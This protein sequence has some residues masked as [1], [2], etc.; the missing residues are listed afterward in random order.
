MMP[1]A[2]L[3]DEHLRGKPIWHAIRHHNVGGGLLID[4]TRVG[5][6]ADLPL[7]SSDANILAWSERAGRIIL[8]ED[9]KT[10][11]AGLVLHLRAGR[12]SPGVFLI[13]PGATVASVLSW[14]E[15]VVAVNRPDTR[16]GLVTYLP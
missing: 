4:T 5:D 15:L 7:G 1:I 14:L 12:T 2:F 10:F 9:A 6:P 16:R 11:P 13:L 3:L 8:T